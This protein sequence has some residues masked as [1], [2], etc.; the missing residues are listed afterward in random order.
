MCKDTTTMD[1][2]WKLPSLLLI[3]SLA[4]GCGDTADTAPSANSTVAAPTTTTPAPAAAQAQVAEKPVD[5][6]LAGLEFDDPEEFPKARSVYEANRSDVA[7]VE[8]YAGILLGVAYAH[9][10]GGNAEQ[11]NKALSLGGEVIMTALQSGVPIKT[12]NTEEQNAVPAELLYGYACVLS[13]D[14]QA[15]KSLDVLNKA[16]SVG[17]SNQQV[18]DNDTDLVAVRAL[19]EY[20]A[21]KA[22]WLVRFEALKQKHIDALIVQAKED[23]KTQESFDFDFQLTNVDG[24]AINLD[25]FKGQVRIVDIWGTWCPPCR[26]EV[27]IFVKLQDKY[28]KYG[29]QVIGLNDER[30]PSPDA[31]IQTVK[32]FMQNASVNYPCAIVTPEVVEQVPDFGG[33]PTTLVIDHTGKVRLK[34]FGFHEFEYFDTVVRELLT[35]AT[36]A[37]AANTN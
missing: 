9:A 4:V 1:I 25:D 21:A 30:G 20:A 17:F 11:S 34:A 5:P 7:A 36:R 12:L 10:Q 32:N 29:L 31:N 26:E 35:E 2:R 15:V 14:E 6:L 27:P 3:G 8:D 16:I 23:L 33:F 22:Q 13:R 19:P 28:N 37:R 24:T 18:L